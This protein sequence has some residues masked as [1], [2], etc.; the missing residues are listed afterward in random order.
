LV[1]HCATLDARK[2]QVQVKHA[3]FE[4]AMYAELIILIENKVYSNN[5]LFDNV[6]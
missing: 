3:T 5:M 6:F 1:Q 4:E 2:T